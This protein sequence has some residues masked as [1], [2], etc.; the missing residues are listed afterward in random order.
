MKTLEEVVKH[1]YNEMVSADNAAFDLMGKV[2]FNNATPEE[3][4]EFNH[5]SEKAMTI[6]DLLLNIIDKDKMT[7][8][9]ESGMKKDNIHTYTDCFLFT[10]DA[11]VR[12]DGTFMGWIGKLDLYTKSHEMTA[13]EFWNLYKNYL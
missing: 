10:K 13:D 12:D 7:E 1:M 6:E 3:E 4:K 9:L 11:D 8:L 5:L 2:V